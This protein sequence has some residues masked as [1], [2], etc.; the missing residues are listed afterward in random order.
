MKITPTHV[1]SLLPIFL[2]PDGGGKA[3]GIFS[4]KSRRTFLNGIPGQ[5][6]P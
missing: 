4:Y 5:V 1:V 2:T 3:V 6:L